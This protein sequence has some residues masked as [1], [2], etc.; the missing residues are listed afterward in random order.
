MLQ[1]VD[2][3]HHRVLGTRGDAVRTMDSFHDVLVHRFLSLLI[4]PDFQLVKSKAIKSNYMSQ[5]SLKQSLYVCASLFPASFSRVLS[6]L[7][8]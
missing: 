2:L 1:S 3:G 7:V 4:F 5:R 6:L 8:K